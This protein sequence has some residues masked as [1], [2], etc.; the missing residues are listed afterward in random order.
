[1][2]NSVRAYRTLADALADNRVLSA[3]V[4]R[5]IEVNPG[6][7]A[8]FYPYL[9][10]RRSYLIP[11]MTSHSD[12][13]LP[14]PPLHL[15]LHCHPDGQYLDVGR[16]LVGS[17]TTILRAGGFSLE[18]GKRILDFGC[19]DGILIRHFCDL[20]EA[21]EVWGVDINGTHITWC[22]QNL[23][24]PF[25]FVT[26]TSFPH[27]PFEDGYFD[28]VYAGSVFTH[29]VDLAEAWLMELKRIVR[30]G[31]K[32]YLTVSDRNTLRI[33]NDDE[34]WKSK[35][36]HADKELHFTVSGFSMF[37]INRTPGAGGR[38]IEAQVF[39]DVDHLR[40][41]WGHYLKVVSITPGAYGFQTAVLLEK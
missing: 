11:S 19:A 1:L 12:S 9:P 36:Q 38:N 15:R 17:M 27:L 25:K 28:L 32:L 39:Y 10:D 13:D 26:T 31:G 34:D 2:R 23:S 5:A 22:Q 4:N 37:T 16:T 3:I 18:R 29:I 6:L 40:T 21:G 30:P 14:L 8:R 20:A 35:L 33:M 41:H 24:P 7:A